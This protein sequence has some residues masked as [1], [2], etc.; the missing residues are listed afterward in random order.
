MKI[1]VPLYDTANAEFKGIKKTL[2][3]IMMRGGKDETF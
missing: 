1:I 2:A 3:H